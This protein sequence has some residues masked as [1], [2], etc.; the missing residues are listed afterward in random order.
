MTTL[1]SKHGLYQ[2]KLTSL[3][4]NNKGFWQQFFSCFT[5]SFEEQATCKYEFLVP[6]T[7]YLRGEVLCEDVS[8]ELEAQFTQADLMDILFEELITNIRQTNNHSEIY[9]KLESID[10]RTEILLLNDPW[11]LD[12]TEMGGYTLLECGIKRK[13]ALRLEVFLADLAVLFPEKKYTV[14]SVLQIL[15]LD[16]IYHYRTGNITNIM[17]EILDLYE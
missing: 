4:C 9:S 14:E 2:K 3:A 17:Q 8:E 15:Y 10:R 16:F 1:Y 6:N 7:E 5:N 13:R 12:D 11:Q